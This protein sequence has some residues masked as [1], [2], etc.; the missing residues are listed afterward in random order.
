MDI[1][2]DSLHNLVKPILVNLPKNDE[3]RKDRISALRK[4]AR[5]EVKWSES[6]NLEGRAEKARALKIKDPKDPLRLELLA[7]SRIAFDFGKIRV[8]RANKL[9]E[10][11]DNLKQGLK[12]EKEMK[13]KGN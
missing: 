11:A 10:L 4:S 8:E 12:K 7:D 5:Q 6:A 13:K 9:T 2:R 1:Y 3:E